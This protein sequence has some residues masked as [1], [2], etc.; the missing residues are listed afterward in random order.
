MQEFGGNQWVE[1]R[2]PGIDMNYYIGADSLQSES[3][4]RITFD[5]RA[6][7]FGLDGLEW[8]TD[9]E[10]EGFQESHEDKFNIF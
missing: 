10:W 2:L 9:P 7:K 8:P 5:L 4:S 6:A 3:H 1:K